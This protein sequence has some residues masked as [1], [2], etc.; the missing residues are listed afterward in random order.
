MMPSY[1]LFWGIYNHNVGYPQKGY[2]M[3][4]QV[5]SLVFGLLQGDMNDLVQIPS[6][7]L[8]AS[9]VQEFSLSPLRTK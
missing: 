7:R 1:S 9:M 5:E 3:S 4:L 8:Q 6:L 2:G